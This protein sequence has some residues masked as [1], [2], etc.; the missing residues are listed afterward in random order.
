[1]TAR[2][3]FVRKVAYVVVL[4]AMLL[5][6]NWLFRPS[7]AGRQGEPGDPGGRL[8]QLR[9]QYHLGQPYLGQIDPA[10]ETIKLATLGMR[11]VAADILWEKANDYKLKKDWANLTATLKQLSR[12]QPNFVGVWEFQAWNIAF[13]VS[14]EFDDYRQRYRWVIKGIEYLQEGM[15]YNEREAILPW[16]VGWFIF[17][18]MGRSDEKKQFRRMFL[19]DDDFHGDRPLA[20]RDSW[21]VAREWFLTAIEMV[22]LR[23]AV[24]R[25]KGPLMYLADPPRCLMN[26]AANL[27]TDGVFGPRAKRAWQHAAEAWEEYGKADIPTSDGSLI[28]LGDLEIQQERAAQLREQLEALAPGLREKLYQQKLAALEPAQREALLTPAD[29]RTPEQHVR[30]VEAEPRAAVAHAEILAWI[31]DPKKRKEAESLAE[32]LTRV[33]ELARVIRHYRDPVNYEYWRLRARVEQTEELLEARQLVFQGNQAFAEADPTA[34]RRA[35][36]RALAAW[37]AVLDKF[38]ILKSDLSTLDDLAEV[39]RMYRAILGQLDEPFPKD[40]PLQ[41]ILNMQE[42]QRRRMEEAAREP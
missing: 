28:H 38:P 3:S 19:A 6:V 42:E 32:E 41:D 11:G 2:R 10:G 30:A 25:K 1:M 4:A 27:E 34:A 15:P 36:D 31:T 8:A 18:K 39:I 37:R 17:Q 21:L 9:D 40:F 14:A 22:E 29:R 16:N 5:V 12:L 20:Q 13:N 35:Y 7:A 23:G 24:M 26:Y 33:E